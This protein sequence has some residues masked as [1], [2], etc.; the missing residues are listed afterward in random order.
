MIDRG[1]KEGNLYVLKH[2]EAVAA[3]V[4]LGFIDNMDDL[5]MLK[6]NTDTFARAIAR[7]ITDYQQLPQ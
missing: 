7:G 4:E 2:T 1:V 3:L 5:A 6:D